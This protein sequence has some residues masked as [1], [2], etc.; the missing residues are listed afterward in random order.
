MEK[1][2]STPRPDPTV[3]TTQRLNSAIEGIEKLSSRD[4]QIINARIDGNDKLNDEKFRGVATQFENADKALN[5]ALAAQKEA[6]NKTEM[7]FGS[8]IANIKEILNGLKTRLDS[9]EGRSKGL[10]DV[11]GYVV[12]LIGI[13]VAVA[14]VAFHL[15]K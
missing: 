1:T 12:G 4:H 11:W 7:L 9:G 15:A 14:S 2:E 10:G 5:A 6:I 3:L 13:I 8:E